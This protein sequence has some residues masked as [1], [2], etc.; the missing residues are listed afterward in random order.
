MAICDPSQAA[1]G[2]SA[3][4]KLLMS[5]GVFGIKDVKQLW[6]QSEGL[7]TDLKGCDGTPGQVVRS[8]DIFLTASIEEAALAL[9]ETHVFPQEMPE[10]NLWRRGF[11]IQVED[12]K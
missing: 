7:L 6:V 11:E 9:G 1:A 2:Y 10:F 12:A 8:I 3:M 4:A 5:D